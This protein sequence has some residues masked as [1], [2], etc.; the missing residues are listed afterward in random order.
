MRLLILLGWFVS[1]VA[2]TQ[3]TPLLIGV[4][5]QN[6][7]F[8]TQIDVNNHFF[9][10]EIDL[11]NEVCN[12]IKIKC[13]YRSVI[14]SKIIPE[15]I[16]KNINL[17]IAAIIRPST[18]VEGFIFSLPYLPSAAKFMTLKDSPINSPG[19]IQDKTV[20]VRRGTLAGGFLFADLVLQKYQNKVKM[21]DYVTTDALIL[22]L[23]NKEVDVLF[24]NAVVVD[25]WYY[26]HMDMYKI[27]GADISVGEGYS[28]M[29]TT[30][31]EM[32]MSKINN[33]L[34]GIFSDGTYLKIYNTYFSQI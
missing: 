25:Y 23:S 1:S 14:V 15:L 7:P 26:N 12:R 6:P 28:I 29:A 4:S 5:G 31:N 3:P 24:T 11:M 16:S 10:F 2:F 30:G 27:I 33:A 34:Q 8:S 19:D 20:G 21:V 22:G 9:G 32:L 13:E 17:S 18:P